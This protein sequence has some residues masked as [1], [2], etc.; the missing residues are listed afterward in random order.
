VGEHCLASKALSTFCRKETAAAEHRLATACLERVWPWKTLQSPAQPL[1]ETLDWRANRQ[2]VCKKARGWIF[3]GR[4]RTKPQSRA[5]DQS[6]KEARGRQ[7]EETE[8]GARA[9]EFIS[10]IVIILYKEKRQLRS[11]PPLG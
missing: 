10:Y 6:D 8:A 3:L 4:R 1:R 2:E 9:T 7:A 5:K 11:Q